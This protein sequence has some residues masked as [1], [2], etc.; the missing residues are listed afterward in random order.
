MPEM[1]VVYSLRSL[2]L[3]SLNSR[4]YAEKMKELQES[5][6]LEWQRKVSIG[7]IQ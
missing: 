1:T 2:Q 3:V 4:E 7:L 5:S 6:Q